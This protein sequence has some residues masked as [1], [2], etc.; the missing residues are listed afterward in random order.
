V[1]ARDVRLDKDREEE[2]E[3]EEE[4]EE[5]EEEEEKGMESVACVFDSWPV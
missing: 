3:E 2:E 5:E 1:L 4:T